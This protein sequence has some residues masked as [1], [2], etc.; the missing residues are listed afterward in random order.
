MF[1]MQGIIQEKDVD[2]KK[3]IFYFLFS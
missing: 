2:E 3:Y 1:T